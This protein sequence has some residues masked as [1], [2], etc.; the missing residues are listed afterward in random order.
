MHTLN[1]EIIKFFFTKYQLINV[2]KYF[3]LINCLQ[4]LAYLANAKN[5]KAEHRDLDSNPESH[6]FM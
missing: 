4:V 3:L 6:S 1:Q 5:Y 2:I